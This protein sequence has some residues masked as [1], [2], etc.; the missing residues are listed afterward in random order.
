MSEN[1]DERLHRLG[2][3]IPDPVAPVAS[4]VPYVIS[5]NQVFVS[6]Q[7]PIEDGRLPFRGKL[8]AELATK[9]GQ[10]AARLCAV[11]IL[12]QMKAACGGDLKGVTRCVKLGGFVNC[13]PDFEEH[14]QVINGASD[15]I[16]EIF[17]DKGKHARFAVGATALPFNV[18]VEID[19]IFEI[20][21]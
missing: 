9:E 7:V 18:A 17:G 21:I 11:N 8:G 6:G 15:L 2:L 4:Y 5:G 3:K 1:I 12:S 13:T 10:A 16:C 20:S 19:A 14:P